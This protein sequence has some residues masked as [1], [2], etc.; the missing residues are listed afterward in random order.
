MTGQTRLRTSVFTGYTRQRPLAGCASVHRKLSVF[1]LLAGRVGSV[2]RTSAWIVGRLDLSEP[3][4]ILN[5]KIAKAPGSAK[6][7]CDG[8]EIILS[9]A[10]FPAKLRAEWA[11]R[12]V[13]DGVFAGRGLC[14]ETI[15]DTLFRAIMYLLRGI[16]YGM[17]E[18]IS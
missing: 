14:R 11:F 16:M 6:F 7:I 13:A 12:R 10:D 9:G 18:T 15:R 2:L 1:L 5:T 3:H 17:R 4:P 8:S